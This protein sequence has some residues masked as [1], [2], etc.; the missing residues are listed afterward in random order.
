VRLKY[1]KRP[2][3]DLDDIA[4]SEAFK[5]HFAPALDGAGKPMRS[6]LVWEIEWPSAWWLSAFVGT[7]SAM[8]KVV[9]YP[10]RRQDAHVPCRGSG[11]LNLG[12]VRP[13]YKDCSKPDLSKIETEAWVTR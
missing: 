10:P 9:G 3:W 5:L 6:N 7:R 8:P 1:L 13:T 2:G 4:K 12:S 11:P